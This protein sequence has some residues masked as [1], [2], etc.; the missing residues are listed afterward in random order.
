[1]VFVPFIALLSTTWSINVDNYTFFGFGRARHAFCCLRTWACFC[2]RGGRAVRCIRPVL[3]VLVCFWFLRQR[4]AHAAQSEFHCHR[5]R[6]FIS[7]RVEGLQKDWFLIQSAQ[8]LFV[9]WYLQQIHP[10][11]WL[12]AAKCFQSH[13]GLKAVSLPIFIHTLKLLLQ[14]EVYLKRA[15]KR[16]G[17]ALTDKNSKFNQWPV[18]ALWNTNSWIKMAMRLWYNEKP[19]TRV[20]GFLF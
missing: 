18:W 8:P 10:L 6:G 5:S 7:G 13:L 2:R 16:N 15:F 20:R 12:S 14:K 11:F 19:R 3:F 4:Q 9:Y 17:P 1:M